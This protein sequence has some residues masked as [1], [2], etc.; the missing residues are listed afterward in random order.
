[1]IYI[2]QIQCSVDG[3]ERGKGPPEN[4]TKIKQSENQIY[5]IVTLKVMVASTAYAEGA[6][7]LSQFFGRCWNV[8]LYL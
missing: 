4:N 7:L 8:L 5:Q 2:L 6:A 3:L 1:M